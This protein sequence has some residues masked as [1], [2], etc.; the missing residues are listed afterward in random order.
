MFCE[1]ISL[2][3]RTTAQDRATATETSR[4]ETGTAN[5][6]EPRIDTREHRITQV[7]WWSSAISTRDASLRNRAENPRGA[8]P[9][10]TTRASAPLENRNS[11]AGLKASSAPKSMAGSPKDAPDQTAMAQNA[12]P[13][14]RADRRG[15]PSKKTA[16]TIGLAEKASAKDNRAKANLVENPN[17][18]SRC[19]AEGLALI[20]KVRDSEASNIPRLNA[21][22]SSPKTGQRKDR[23]TAKK[24]A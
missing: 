9:D 7:R 17:G 3:G 5:A 20:P 22:I 18:R 19:I 21:G 24:G 10:R 1:A 14:N 2:T 15:G 8:A 16:N 23:T 13:P 6:K 12:D 4:A 11:T